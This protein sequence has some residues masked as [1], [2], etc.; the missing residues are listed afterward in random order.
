VYAAVVD[1][2]S[3]RT[4]DVARPFAVNASLLYGTEFRLRDDPTF[5]AGSI[6][7]RFANDAVARFRT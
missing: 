4:G 2:L 1:A 7:A 6:Q 5:D 3:C